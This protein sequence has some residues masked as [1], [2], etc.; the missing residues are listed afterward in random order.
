MHRDTL[1]E[2]T[3]IRYDN[4]RKNY[5]AFINTRTDEQLFAWAL[6]P[7]RQTPILFFTPLKPGDIREKLLYDPIVDSEMIDTI[8][9]EFD[10]L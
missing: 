3:T 9:S 4:R 8:R 7:S 5:N 1:A 10:R 2:A 6:M